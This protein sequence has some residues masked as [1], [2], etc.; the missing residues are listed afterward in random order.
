MTILIVGLVIF[1][2][3]HVLTATPLRSVMV[4]AIGEKPYKGMFSLLSFVGL[5]LMIWGFGMSRYGPDSAIIVFNPPSWSHF[6]TLVLVAIAL[7]LIGASHGKGYMRKWV[8]HPMSLGVGLW[9]LG[10]LFSNGNMNEVLLFGSFVAY[11]IFDVLLCTI[12][13]KAKTFEPEFKSD[14]KAIVI[15]G[16]LFAAILFFHYN[17]FGVSVV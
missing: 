3:I 13:G 17:I 14:M 6:V 12:K 5:G 10:H 2:G 4:G 9:A 16:A 11:A 15:G 7:V 8:K 1:F